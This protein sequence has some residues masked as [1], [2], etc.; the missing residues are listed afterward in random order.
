MTTNGGEKEQP[1][2]QPGGEEIPDTPVFLRDAPPTQKKMDMIKWGLMHN[3]TEKDLE[4]QGFNPKT[5][6]MAAYDLEKEGYRKRP[7]KS[8]AV[9]KTNGGEGEAKDRAVAPYSKSSITPTKPI[10]PEYL[11]DQ[12]HLPMDGAQ[13]KT[14]ETGMKFGASMLV[15]GVRVAQELSNMGLQQARPIMDMANAMRQGEAA[16]AKGAAAEAAILAAEQVKDDMMP[17]LASATQKEQA[18]SSDPMRQMATRMFEPMMQ[19]MM[20]MFMPGVG[21]NLPSDWTRSTRER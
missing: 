2:E 11:I 15:L 9:K 10:P 13:A 12:I 5:V 21:G 3:I 14:F 1:V 7:A 20:N 18:S 16:A 17:F 8:R 19:R 6:R 4:D